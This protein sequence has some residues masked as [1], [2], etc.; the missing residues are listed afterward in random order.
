MSGSTRG[1]LGRRP[2]TGNPLLPPGQ[3][4]VGDGWPVL[5]AEPTPRIATD[6][7]SITVD[8]EVEQ[9]SAWNWDEAHALPDAEYRG[10]IHCVTTW[11][12]FDTRFGGVSVDSLLDVAKPRPEGRFVMATSSTGYTTNLRMEDVTGGKAWIV[13]EFDGKPLTAEHGGPVRMLVPHLY[14]WKSAKWISKLT[15][16]TE[17]R[18][19]FWEQ[20]GY[21]D[22]GD[23]WTQQR[24]QGD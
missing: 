10:A 23:P 24:Y 20:R 16:R 18:P 15:V 12:K 1:F 3:Y 13:W 5:T 2:P 17:D 6:T 21:H 8:G 4:D 22:Q 9:P 19:G 7:W 11:S 14:F